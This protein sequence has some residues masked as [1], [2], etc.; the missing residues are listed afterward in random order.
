ML[1]RE[2][3][4]CPHIAYEQPDHEETVAM[5]K[6]FGL[7]RRRSPPCLPAM[8]NRPHALWDHHEPLA[9]TEI[10]KRCRLA[11]SESAASRS[12]AWSA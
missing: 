9:L 11:R 3:R 6:L 8:R 12:S 1:A 5:I 10:S 2:R 4:S 7:V